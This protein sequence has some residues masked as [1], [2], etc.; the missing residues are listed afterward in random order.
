MVD[1]THDP[2]AIV[3]HLTSG[4]LVAAPAKEDPKG[5][6]EA[7]FMPT[8]TGLHRVEWLGAADDA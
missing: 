8:R 7:T 3:E 6:L 2:V 1:D 5:Y 4:D